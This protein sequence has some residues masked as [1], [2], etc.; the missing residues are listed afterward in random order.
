MT[1]LAEEVARE[2]AED[3]HMEGVHAEDCWE[4]CVADM[5]VHIFRGL[6]AHADEAVRDRDRDWFKAFGWNPDA[7]QPGDLTP[8]GMVEITREATKA[9]CESLAGALKEFQA[10]RGR[11]EGAHDVEG[12]TNCSRCWTSYVEE[13]AK[14]DRALSAWEGKK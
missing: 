2:I 7:M 9:A 6:R 1:P 3:C 10:K 14:L 8:E 4:S 13:E 12:G 5:Q 11:H